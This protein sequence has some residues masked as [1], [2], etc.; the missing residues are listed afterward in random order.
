MALTA[1]AAPVA[2][3]TI[4]VDDYLDVDRYNAMTSGAVNSA[5]ENFEGATVG[6]VANGYSTAVGTFSTIGGVGNGGTVTK[7]PFAN[8]GSLLAIRD[9]NVYG[10]RSTTKKLTGDS[11]D[12]QFLDSN[13][14]FGISWAASLGGSMFNKI[15]LTVTDAAEFGNDLLIEVANASYTVES[16][17]M[18]P[19]GGGDRQRV[20]KISFGDKVDAANITFSH[21]DS[22]GLMRNDGFS[23]DDITVSEVPLPASALLLLA[24]VGGLAAMRRRKS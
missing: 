17:Y 24:G 7:A 1:F 5:Y 23:L 18:L 4:S 2:A 20:V 19:A 22:N 6:N 15:V 11:G 3:A 9:G 16:K 14:T 10:R 13:D 12:D 8:D 21:F